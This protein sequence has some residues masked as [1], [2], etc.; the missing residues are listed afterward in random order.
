M[1]YRR[2]TDC[3][4]CAVISACRPD[5]SWTL[6]FLSCVALPGLMMWYYTF[7]FT[8]V[9]LESVTPMVFGLK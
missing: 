3:D 9:K 7:D 2:T 4:G 5:G 1:Q 8:P 6:S